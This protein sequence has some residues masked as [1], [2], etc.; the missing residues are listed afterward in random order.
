MVVHFPFGS[1]VKPIDRPIARPIARLVVYGVIINHG[2][3]QCNHKMVL[4]MVCAGVCI[5]FN[6]KSVHFCTKTLI[7]LSLGITF[8]FIIFH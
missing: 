1:N 4:P 2:V 3:T 8:L 7:F 5:D 6:G